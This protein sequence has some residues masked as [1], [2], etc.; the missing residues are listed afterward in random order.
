MPRQVSNPPNPWESAREW[1]GEPPLAVLEVF[2]ERARSVLSENSSPD[3]PFR[4]SVNPYRGCFHA[5]AYCYARP[6]H[7]YLGWGAGTDFDRRIVV[8]LNAPEVLDH[9]LKKK[10]LGETIHFSGNTDCY[11][12]LEASYRLTRQ[13]L[14]VCHR[15]ERAVAVITKGTLI[16]RDEAILADLARGPGATVTLSIPFDDAAM[17]RAIEPFASPPQERYETL[18]ILSRAGVETGIS[19]APLIPGL[20]D[21]QIPAILE[22]AREAGARYAFLTLLRLSRE[23]SVVFE[24][25]LRE[26]LPGRANKVLSALEEMR[27]GQ[28]SSPDFGDRMRGHGPRWDAVTRLF[29]TTRRRLGYEEAKLGAARVLP[30]KEDP[31]GRLF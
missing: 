24:E 25:R 28:R 7:Q 13:C 31:Q 14:E 27:R 18:R 22:K 30:K 21:S 3:I 2:E 17:S 4:F 1:L 8:K 16:R 10:A 26:A 20:N 19:L 23:V 15:H 5:C 12:P 11:Q 9:E 6:T 29:E